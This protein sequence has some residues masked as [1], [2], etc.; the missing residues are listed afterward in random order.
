MRKAG[1][2]NPVQVVVAV[3]TNGESYLITQ[4]KPDDRFGSLWE[5]PGGKLEQG[6][7]LRNCL[8]RE[9]EEELSVQVEVGEEFASIDHNY[10]AL[11]VHLH[12]FL[13]RISSGEPKAV[14]CAAI[15]WV[16]PGD[17][18]R[19]QFPEANTPVIDRLARGIPEWRVQ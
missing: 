12:F 5:F 7:S 16:R 13:C 8:E 4:R 6:E 1:G 14:G 17:L 3:V 11:D 15:R 9:L 10:D 18:G 2:S 19:F